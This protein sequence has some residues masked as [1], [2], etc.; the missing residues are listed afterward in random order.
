MATHIMRTNLMTN[1]AFN[2]W[3][4]II[5]HLSLSAPDKP[6]HILNKSI[7]DITIFSN[8][9]NEDTPDKNWRDIYMT[10]FSVFNEIASLKQ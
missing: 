1:R 7:M 6:F 5:T 9:L 2:S 10:S 3:R 8:F 4:S